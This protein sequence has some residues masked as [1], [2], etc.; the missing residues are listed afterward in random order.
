MTGITG[1]QKMPYSQKVQKLCNE[2]KAFYTY[3]LNQRKMLDLTK[4]DK[5]E[6][7]VHKLNQIVDEVQKVKR[8]NLEDMVNDGSLFVTQLRAPSNQK[9]ITNPVSP[10][11]NKQRFGEEPIVGD[12]SSSMPPMK[13]SQ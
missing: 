11:R 9:R 4:G 7:R 1:K 8:K 5:E 2:N 13:I 6:M 12:Y 10:S 3:K